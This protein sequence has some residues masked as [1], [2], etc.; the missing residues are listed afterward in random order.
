MAMEDF[1]FSSTCCHSLFLS[2]VCLGC[3]FD[4]YY[5]W[6]ASYYICGKEEELTGWLDR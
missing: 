2:L 6:H 4:Y 3:L 1:L 5:Y